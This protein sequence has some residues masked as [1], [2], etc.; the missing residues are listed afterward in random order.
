MLRDESEIV[1][2]GGGVIGLCTALRLRGEGREVLLVERNEPGSGT[3]SG[4][5]GVLATYECVP[6][7]TPHVLKSLP[8][9]LFDKNSPLS[10]SLTALPQLAPWLARFA[11]AM[12]ARHP[13]EVKG[14]RAT[15]L[16]DSILS[17][18][19]GHLA[20]RRARSG[21]RSAAPTNQ[22]VS[23]PRRGGQEQAVRAPE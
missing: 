5:A 23:A 16:V 18:R 9:L 10:I 3:S 2:A 12:L 7:G 6:L 21:R 17:L 11:R 1:I 8:R 13:G 4:N 20:S 15:P 22:S 14:R 19:A